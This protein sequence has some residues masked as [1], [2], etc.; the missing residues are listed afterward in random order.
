MQEI[1]NAML[2]GEWVVCEN[3]GH[4]LG[5]AI[6]DKKPTG[7]EIKCHSCK[8]INLVNRPKKRPKKREKQARQYTIP[9]CKHCKNY[10]EF[11]D[12]C[13][14]RL[15]YWGLQARA[16]AGASKGCQSFDP[17]EEYK[18]NYKEMMKWL[19]LRDIKHS[20]E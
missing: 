18:E 19:K 14:A 17:L 10:K 6:G 5:R 9:H 2:D 4:K 3:C 1:K 20:G 15:M 11:T 8:A 16:K 12:T 13:L 7:I